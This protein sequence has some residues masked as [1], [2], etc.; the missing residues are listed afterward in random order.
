ME[1]ITNFETW[2]D[3]ALYECDYNDVY[4][5]YRC[6]ADETDM[7]QFSIQKNETQKKWFVSCNGCDDKLMLTEKS[8]PVFLDIIEKT[9]CEDMDIEG[10]YA[11]Y[12]AMERD[13]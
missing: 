10:Y 1:T 12:H 5:L 2:F 6:V 11:Y 9:Y 7:G 3:E 13:D 4:C 8:R